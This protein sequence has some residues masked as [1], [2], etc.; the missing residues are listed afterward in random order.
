MPGVIMDNV[1]VEESVRMPGLNEATN[2]VPSSL[3]AHEKSAQLS[4]SMNGPVHV[5]GAGRG[6][7]GLSQHSETPVH[8]GNEAVPTPFEIPHITQGFFPFGTL[9][10]RAVQQCWNDLSELITELAAIQVPTDSAVLSAANGKPAS[11]QSPENVHKKMRILDFAHAK[12]AEFIKLLVLSQWSRQ[13]SEVSRLIDIQAFIRARHSA[14]AAAVQYVGEMKRDLVRAQVANP[15]LKTAL[16]V[17]SKGRVLNLPD[18]GYKPPKALTARATLRKLHRI[19]RIISVRLA[20]HDQVPY[21]LRNY[22]VHDGRAT[23]TV[24]GEFELDLSVAEKANSSQFFFVDIRFL[25][26]P[27]SPVPKGRI[28]NE[29]DAKI[30]EI[31]CNDGL[32]GCFNFLHGLVLTNKINTLFRQA[33]DLARGLWSDAL[34]IELLHR[35]LVVQYWPTRAGPKSWLEIGVQ[36]RSSTK[37]ANDQIPLVGLRWM[38]EGQ[39]ANSDAIQFDSDILSME[40]VL[41]SVIALHTSHLLST[42]FATLRKHILFSN[43]VLS[44]RAQLSPTEPGDCYLDIQLTSSRAL[45]VSVEPLSG[46]IILSSTPS[47]L[48]R[49]EPERA[50]NKSAID[51]LL[52]RVS[53]LRCTTAVDEIESGTKEVGLESVGQR[54]L[55]LDFRR[56]FPP[57]VMRS[58]FFTHQLWDRR[59]VAAATSSMDG[60]SWWLV[61]SRQAETSR[62]GRYGVLDHISSS[63]S[64]HLVS[65]TLMSPKWRL[66]HTAFAEL[67]H[68][69]TGILAIYA[70]AR[71]LAELPDVSFHPPLEKLQLGSDLQVPDLVFSYK[72]TSLPPAFRIASPSGLERGTYL[73]NSVRIRFHGID[74]QR[75]TVALVAYGSLR[76]RVKALL[77]LISR[78]DSSIIMQDKGS[79]FALRLPSLAGHSVVINLFERLQRLECILSILQSLIQKGMEPRSLSLSEITFAYGIGNKFSARFGI[80]FSGPALSENLEITRALAKADTLFNLNLRVNFDSPSPHR[81]LQEPLTV[82]LN[83]RFAQTGVDSIL[84]LMSD[85]FPLLQS[86]DHITSES[87]QTESSIV[88]VTVRSPTVFQFHYPLLKS[89]F[90]L[91]SRPRQGRTVWVLEHVKRADQS[92]HEQVTTAVKEKIYNSKGDGWQGLGDGALSSLEKVGNLLS[93]FHACLSSCSP[94]LKQEGQGEQPTTTGLPPQGPPA[95]PAAKPEKS[96][97]KTGGLGNTTDVITID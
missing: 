94:A 80:D 59:W 21:P 47:V 38:R 6:I 9:V 72:S 89:R 52:F 60:D 1:S 61:Q 15:D 90:Q 77:P 42:A 23:F 54:G 24:P 45:R 43:H 55:G 13:A 82:A 67:V 28:F 12:R 65:N 70:N 14:Y 84:S 2:G 33:T 56:L 95:A 4:A 62:G 49:P 76:Y 48:E 5:N 39:Q 85:T 35:T 30:N 73:Q 10:N 96:L 92:D 44:L 46:T 57:N 66:E 19:N 75:Q 32:M 16:E 50:P 17:L 7:D 27:S 26:S 18:L 81:R 87:P 31:L 63:P 78:M 74:H 34:R 40:Q 64:A 41:R 69:L 93:E 25:F 91:S 53:R 37:E 71:C 3:G 88:H 79:G 68:G 29:L 22:R 8:Y 51:E 58:A 11:N 83:Q 36:R 20:L 86:L 97:Q